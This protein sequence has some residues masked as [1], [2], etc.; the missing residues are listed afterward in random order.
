MPSKRQHVQHISHVLA[1][2][3]ACQCLGVPCEE[4]YLAVLQ[5]Q[6]T[7]AVSEKHKY[8]PSSNMYDCMPAQILLHL[9]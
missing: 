6:D 1:A 7:P 4:Q 5:L 8:A 2:V 3:M 9:V